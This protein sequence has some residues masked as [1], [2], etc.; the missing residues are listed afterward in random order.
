MPKTESEKGILNIS[1]IWM[2]SSQDKFTTIN[3]IYFLQ[4]FS[5]KESESEMR[6]FKTFW[7]PINYVL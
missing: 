3:T 7:E 5:L 4:S 2:I 6:V 1:T